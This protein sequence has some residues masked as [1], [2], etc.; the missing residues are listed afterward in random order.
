MVMKIYTGTSP[1][2]ER[3][4]YDSEQKEKARSAT[5]WGACKNLGCNN[6]R[7]HGS[8]YC[9]DCSDKFKK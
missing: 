3:L 8:C 5:F 6:A 2:D 4:I 7:R 9:Q 1:F